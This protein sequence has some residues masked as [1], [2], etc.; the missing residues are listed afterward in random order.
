ML[1][2]GL[3][4]AVIRGQCRGGGGCAAG[5]GGIQ[6]KLIGRGHGH[7]LGDRLRLPPLN[8]EQAGV[9][10]QRR[11]ANQDRQA[12]GDDGRDTPATSYRSRTKVCCRN[13][14]SLSPSH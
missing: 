3:D 14:V 4:H 8:K 9:E 11:H 10:P 6:V 5:I 12:Q 1:M 2:V 13:M 7:G